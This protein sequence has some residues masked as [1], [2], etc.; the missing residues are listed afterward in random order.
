MSDD[1]QEP[2]VKQDKDIQEANSGSQELSQVSLPAALSVKQLAELLRVS[3][4]EV[5]KQLMR[6][7]VMANINQAI[8]FDTAA[9]LAADFGYKAKK[10]PTPVQTKS[11]ATAKGGELAPCPPVITIMGHVDHG[12]TSLLDAIR[13]TNVIAS[14]AGAITQHIGA[15][16]AE[17]GGRRITFLDTPG[18]EA[19]TAMRARG[20]RATDIAVL[21]VAAD[22]GVMPQTVEAINH[23]RA[24]EVPIVVAIN[25]I[26]KANAN[27]DRIKQQ[28]ADLGLIVEEWGGDTICVPIS[29][30]K[31]QGIDDLLENL[32]LVAD[33]L[34]LKAQP[35]CPAEGIVIE[36]RL[37]KTKGPLATL[38]VQKGNLKP[39]DNLVIS[40]T[41]GKVKAMF[42]DLGKQIRKAEPATPVE[43]LG[44][45]AVPQAGDSF[46]VV[47]SERA[48]RMA[49]DKQK[50]VQQEFSTPAKTLS[51][52]DL[53]TQISAG[54]VKELNVVLK[55]DV[56]GS[57]EPI[58]DS[59]E[60]L[61][62]EKIRVR[63]IHSGS[64][65]ITES[66]VLL[67]LASKG[68]IIGFNS[69]PEPGAHRLAE[70]EGTSIRYYS[71]IYELVNDVAKALKGMLEPTL[72][73]VI[74]G[75]AEVLAIFDTGKKTR[76]AGVSVK[77]GKARRDALARVLRQGESIH[78]SRVSSLRRFKEDVREVSTGL[79]C[80]V[81][82][83][84]FSDFQVGDVIQF[85]RQEK[86]T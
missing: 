73:D 23:A 17:V 52:T 61:A 72:T 31:K 10:Q 11:S 65:S 49:L 55:T 51:L 34:E 48:A 50:G 7:G 42:N 30:K 76:V 36:A 21:V 85:Y 45:N 8:D 54:Q 12:K 81:G 75:H 80:G 79:E 25:K 35:D 2:I 62:D 47:A 68:I 66:D 40:N 15:Y 82:I 44:I 43:V 22:D 38:L 69:R 28:L 53:S 56:Q 58:K 74:E 5:I 39:G 78:E 33:M 77:E 83:E 37:D 26:D 32:L 60:Q 20:A 64:G 41:W 63:V 70:L 57:I 84:D 71:V 9:V 1:R 29:A 18:H 13:Q 67:A 24:A 19:F 3:A 86:V 6:N 59:L 46:A 27:S 4:V 16:Q 14:E